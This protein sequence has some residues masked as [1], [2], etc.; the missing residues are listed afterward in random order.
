VIA[1]SRKRVPIPGSERRALA[2]ALRAGKADPNEQMQVSVY[3]R[4]SAPEGTRAAVQE[5]VDQ[6]PHQRRYLS[7][8]EFAAS[9]GADPKD[10]DAVTSFAKDYGLAVERAW[11]PPGAS[12]C[13]AAPLRR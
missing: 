2:G 11:T 3:V 1:T 9:F 12:W 13:S 6:P 4:S 5:L 7:R 8:E 10:L